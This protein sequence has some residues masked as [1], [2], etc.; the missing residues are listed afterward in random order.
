MDIEVEMKAG[1]GPWLPQPIRSATDVEKVVVPDVQDRLG[2]VMDAIRMTN[3]KL[4][5]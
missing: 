4:D 2:Y 3:E 1:V 5:G